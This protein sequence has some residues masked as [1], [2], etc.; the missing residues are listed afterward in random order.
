MAKE[1]EFQF[2][3]IEVHGAAMPKADPAGAN[4]VV[5]GDTI[6]I[7]GQLWRLRGWDAPPTTGNCCDEEARKGQDAKD[8]LEQLI[9]WA[10]SRGALQ[11]EVR[12]IRDRHGRPLVDIRVEGQDIGA[13]MAAHG[14]AEPYDGRGPKPVFCNCAARRRLNE[15]QVMMADA[16]KQRSFMDRLRRKVVGAVGA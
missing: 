4:A 6:K 12:D 15:A 1:L 14:L 16:R 11:I 8:Y 9:Q 13:V 7:G 10:A 3:R 2:G 5:D